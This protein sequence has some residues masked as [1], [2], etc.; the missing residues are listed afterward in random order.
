MDHSLF[1]C[2][3]FELVIV[4]MISFEGL[5]VLH[6]RK[7]YNV[8]V[9]F[10]F[11]KSFPLAW[12]MYRINVFRFSS[13]FKVKLFWVFLELSLD[14]EVSSGPEKYFHFYRH[15]FWFKNGIIR[16][17][18]NF[19]FSKKIPFRSATWIDFPDSFMWKK[20]LPCCF[21]RW[22]PFPGCLTPDNMLENF[23]Y[24]I[25]HPKQVDGLLFQ[26]IIY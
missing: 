24:F 11:Y 18:G 23:P 4:K 16:L 10:L 6:I 17:S 7:F 20:I 15:V 3:F 25:P 2:F 22:R 26:H 5:F 8:L 14:S 19:R 9:T 12:D 13:F 1:Q 21:G